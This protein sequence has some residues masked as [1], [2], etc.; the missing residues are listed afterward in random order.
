VFL[1]PAEVSSSATTDVAFQQDGFVTLTT[2]VETA[3]TNVSK[4]AIQTGIPV[5]ELG[6][7][8]TMDNALTTGGS[9][10][11]IPTAAM[12]LMRIQICAATG[13]IANPE[14]LNAIMADAFPR[15]GFVM[16]TMTAA[17]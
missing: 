12:V 13:Q 15:V 9:A 11:E 3:V 1:D 2:T 10:M 7:N 8:A 5:V 4:D 16:E 17:T 14:S 6:S